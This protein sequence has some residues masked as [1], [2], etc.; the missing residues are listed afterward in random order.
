QKKIIIGH[1]AERLKEVGTRARAEIE[2]MLGHRCH[3]QLF[4]R[5]EPGWRDKTNLLDEMGIEKK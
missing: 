4:V 2:H 1:N 3:L 5:V